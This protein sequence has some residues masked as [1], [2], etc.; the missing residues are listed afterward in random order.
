MMNL[1]TQF[2]LTMLQVSTDSYL[3][4]IFQVHRYIYGKV[5]GFMKSAVLTSRWVWRYPRCLGWPAKETRLPARHPPLKKPWW[6]L[7]AS[8][9]SLRPHYHSQPHDTRTGYYLDST[10]TS[11]IST[12]NHHSI[13][14]TMNDLIS[15]LRLAHTPHDTQITT[16]LLHRPVAT[17]NE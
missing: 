1:L 6:S 10:D 17:D 12:W 2:R 14:C 16:A 7:R 11:C 13:L 5:L 3:E 15:R 8:H 4:T 9:F